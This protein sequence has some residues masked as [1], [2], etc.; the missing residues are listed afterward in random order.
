MKL[1]FL[2]QKDAWFIEHSHAWYRLNEM[3]EIR[4]AL[5][6]LALSMVNQHDLIEQPHQ[7][8]TA[9]VFQVDKKSISVSLSSPDDL[10]KETLALML[11]KNSLINVDWTTRKFS[12]G[13]I[14]SDAQLTLENVGAMYLEAYL[15]AREGSDG[16]ALIVSNNRT[17]KVQKV[18]IKRGKNTR[19]PV[20]VKGHEGKV[21]V[22]LQCEPEQVDQ[23]SDP[24]QLGFV[25]ITEEA[26][27][28]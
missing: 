5:S 2:L 7:A 20:L 3:A 12:D 17:G 18:W 6:A 16:K 22:K 11:D 4:L 10:V 1:I 26:R 9:S 8:G 28:A 13:W 24:R 14:S 25:L 19:I 27:A 23:S 21:C 15:P